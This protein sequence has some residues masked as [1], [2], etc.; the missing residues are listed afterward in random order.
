VKQHEKCGE[1]TKYLRTKI[2]GLCLQTQFRKYRYN[3]GEDIATHVSKLESLTRR[4]QGLNEPIS[5]TMLMT[6]ILNT[7]PPAYRHF[8]SAW[9]LTP[10]AERTLDKLTSR[11]MIEETR[12]RISDVNLSTESALMAKKQSKGNTAQCTYKK[13]KV[14]S[15]KIKLKCWTCGGPYLRHDCT[16]KKKN[17]SDQDKQKESTHGLVMVSTRSSNAPDLIKWIIDSGCTEHVYWQIEYFINY[18]RLKEAVTFVLGDSRSLSGRGR[19]NQNTFI[20]GWKRTLFP[21]C[22]VCS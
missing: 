2:C 5:N 9:D 7:L 17:G 18:E 8:H 14:D 12:M 6:T 21:K 16:Q 10:T 13:D 11:L 20:C 22:D 15:S 4:L 19:T 1:I 3:S